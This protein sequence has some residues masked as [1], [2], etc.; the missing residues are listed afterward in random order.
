MNK[1]TSI[2]LVALLGLSATA[3]AQSPAPSSVTPG[4]PAA[5]IS[6]DVK[7]SKAKVVKKKAHKHHKHVSAKAAA[8]K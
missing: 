7:A 1:R 3:F 5:S 8:D 6:H 4:A 2:I